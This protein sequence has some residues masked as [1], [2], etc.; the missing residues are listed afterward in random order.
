HS[1]MPAS[2]SESERTDL[3]NRAVDAYKR[4]VAPAWTRLHDF[5]VTRYLHA[6]R[7]ATSASALPNGAALY[8]FNVRW[9]TTTAQHAQEIHDIGLAEVKRIRAEMDRV[10]QSTGFRGGYDAFKQFLRT[11]PQFYF[12]DAEALLTAYRDIAKR[13]DPE[14]ARL[15]GR[16]P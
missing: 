12:T 11:D 15:F 6:C 4:G 9:H 5:L 3:R 2:F 13:A 1:K 7:D 10:M 8:A 16:L 14:L